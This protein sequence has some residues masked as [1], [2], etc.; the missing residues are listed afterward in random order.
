M[1][2]AAALGV[3]LLAADAEHA[4]GRLDWAPERCTAGGLLH[5]GALMSLAD[6]VGGVCA[7]L[8]LPDGA[9]GTATTSSTTHLF[10][11]VREGYV[12]ATARPLHRG[13]SS[14]VVQTE[15]VDA[16]GRAVGQVTQ[17]QAVLR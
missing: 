17:A 15:L 1:P 2:Y 6:S 4:V 14:I 13:R 8:C 10:R 11:A 7:F 5:G 3:R 12:V 16:Q 9:T